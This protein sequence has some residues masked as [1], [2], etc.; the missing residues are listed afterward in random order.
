M[1]SLGLEPMALWTNKIRIFFLQDINKAASNHELLLVQ[2][3]MFKAI[4]YEP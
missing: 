1:V 3:D 4:H 2:S